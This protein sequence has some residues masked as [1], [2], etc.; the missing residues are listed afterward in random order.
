MAIKFPTNP[1]EGQIY[2]LS[3]GRKFIRKNGKWSLH[4]NNLPET[5]EVSWLL[6][7]ITSD[8]A[9]STS[10]PQKLWFDITTGVVHYKYNDGTTTKWI[11]PGEISIAL[12]A[13]N[14]IDVSKGEL[15]TKTISG[16]TTLSVANVPAAGKVCSFVLEITN[17][18]SAVVTWWP[19]I[20]WTSGTP[21]KLTTAGTDVIGFYSN[22]GGATWRGFEMSIDNKKAA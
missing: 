10:V 16:V 2:E 7:P 13:G 20:S 14:S 12:G 8:V 15:F 18:G 5:G 3:P 19:E 9:P 6:A 4:A 1:L 21:P 22:D 17:G 11:K